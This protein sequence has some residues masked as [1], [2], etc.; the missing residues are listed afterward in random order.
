MTSLA[1]RLRCQGQ[2]IGLVPTMGALH[3]GHVSLIRRAA[4]QNDVVIVTIFVN[5]LQ[6]GPG[7]DFA[8]YPRTL[9][10]DLRLARSAGADVVFAPAV[11]QMYPPGYQA[12]VEV[13][14]LASRWEGAIRPGHFRGVATVVTLLLQMT[15]PTN[16]YVGQKDYQQA[17]LIRRLV[18]DLRFPVAAHMLPTVREADGLAM[19]SR[20]AYLSASQRRRAA[21]LFQALELARSRIRAGERRT[22]PV[23]RAM[24]RLIR[25]KARARIDYAAVVDAD[26][27]TP[28]PRLRGR[29]AVLLAVRLGRT[30]L[31]DNLLVEVS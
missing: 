8:R 11:E 20:N 4:A 22:A 3:E 12:T 24:R 17:L 21:A 2:C 27:L 5:P 1:A 19:S 29:L 25:E 7:E 6:F 30:R 16:L 28:T 31:I 14:E 23:M 13:G 26:T 9:R 10:R 15:H 18:R